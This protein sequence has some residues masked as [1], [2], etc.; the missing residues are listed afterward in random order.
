LA[1]LQQLLGIREV[2]GQGGA[3]TSAECPCSLDEIKI[4]EE[5]YLD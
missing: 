3:D 5:I 2:S 4:S 1:E